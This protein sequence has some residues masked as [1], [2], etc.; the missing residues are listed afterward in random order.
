[1]SWRTE[2]SRSGVLRW[3]RKYLETTTLVALQPE[4][5]DLDVLLLEDAL[6]RLVG[7]AGRPELPGGLRRRDG[8][9][10]GSSDARRSG[11]WR[12][13]RWDRCRRSSRRRGRRGGGGLLGGRPWLCPRPT[14]RSPPTWAAWC[15]ARRRRWSWLGPSDAPPCPSRAV[16][17]AFPVVVSVPRLLRAGPRT[18]SSTTVAGAGFGVSVGRVTSRTIRR[19][20]AVVKAKNYKM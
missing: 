6:A 13:S 16:A 2:V 17:A 3:P 5:R 20:V 18:T 14:W 12:A 7:D 19:W 9:P 15:R 4:V 10:G 11:P 1:M 8:R